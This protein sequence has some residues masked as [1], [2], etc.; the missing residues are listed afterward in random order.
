MTEKKI[1]DVEIQSKMLIA[2]KKIDWISFEMIKIEKNE[3]NDDDN[4]PRLFYIT[5]H[6]K[7][8][9]QVSQFSEENDDN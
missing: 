9:S 4:Q 7:S 3:W 5:L 2:R 8:C 1:K 6:W